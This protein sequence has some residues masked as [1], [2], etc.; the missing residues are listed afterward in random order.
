MKEIVTLGTLNDLYDSVDTS[1][2]GSKQ[3]SLFY[4]NEDDLTEGDYDDNGNL[5]L[6]NIF[7]NKENWNSGQDILRYI[8]YYLSTRGLVNR[9]GVSFSYNKY[10]SIYLSYISEDDE[11]TG[12]ITLKNE[13]IN[14]IVDVYSI[15]WYKNRGTTDFIRKNGRDISLK[16]YLMIV[17]MLLE[18]KYIKEIYD[19]NIATRI[20]NKKA[21]ILCMYYN[22]GQELIKNLYKDKVADISYSYIYKVDNKTED[23]ISASFSNLI[24]NFIDKTKYIIVPYSDIFM[25]VLADKNLNV[26][27]VKPY[28]NDK[29]IWIKKSINKI[30]DLIKRRIPV[31]DSD[32]EELMNVCNYWKEDLAKFKLGNKPVYDMIYVGKD[33]EY[34]GERIISTINK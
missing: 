24:D 34:N 20:K 3:T 12:I 16:D 27:V 6:G 21:R 8:F 13:D 11:K 10:I 15:G 14:S 23:E 32:I 5:I 19:K 1:H 4:T 18:D 26:T 17:N 30:N 31:P 7:F 22:C 2:F 25:N 33:E 9:C 29:S 28:E